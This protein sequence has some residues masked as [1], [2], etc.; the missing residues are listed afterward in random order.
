MKKQRWRFTKGSPRDWY[1]SGCGT[2]LDPKD[3]YAQRYGFCDVYCGYETFG[4]SVSD[5]I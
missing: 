5:F 1:C 2:K 4:L 3:R